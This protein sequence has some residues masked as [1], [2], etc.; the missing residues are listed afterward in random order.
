MSAWEYE[1][2][3]T[4]FGSLLAFFGA[5]SRCTRQK[6]E[7]DLCTFVSAALF[8]IWCCRRGGRV[9]ILRSV[10]KKE[11]QRGLAIAQT[12]ARA[13]DLNGFASRIEHLSIWALT[14]LD[15]FLR[16]TLAVKDGQQPETGS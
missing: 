6:G 1:A 5:P 9:Y 8:S 7:D 15:H 4:R 16:H 11:K 14:D 13:P 12:H 3:T 10:Y 2:P